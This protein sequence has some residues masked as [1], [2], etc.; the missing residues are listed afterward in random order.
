MSYH[1]EL[2]PVRQSEV[3]ACCVCA[4]ADSQ[5]AVPAAEK[6]ANAAAEGIPTPMSYRVARCPMSSS[7]GSGFVFCIGALHRYTEEEFFLL[8]VRQRQT[9]LPSVGART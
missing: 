9:I 3:E 4:M 5:T 7:E 1:V 2:E 8:F 6:F